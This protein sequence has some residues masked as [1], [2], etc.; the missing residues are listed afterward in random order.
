MD[1]DFI[2]GIIPGDKTTV[3]DGAKTAH[4]ALLTSAK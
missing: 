1:K 4:H 3:A 2:D